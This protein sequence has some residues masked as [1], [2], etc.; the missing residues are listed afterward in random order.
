MAVAELIEQ[1]DPRLDVTWYARLQ[2]HSSRRTKALHWT[3]GCP[4][5]LWV[6][7]ARIQHLAGDLLVDQDAPLFEGSYAL[8]GLPEGHAAWP[9]ADCAIGLRPLP[10]DVWRTPL[11]EA[12]VLRVLALEGSDV[13]VDM[14]ARAGIRPGRRVRFTWQ[15]ME[16]TGFFEARTRANGRELACV[17]IDLVGRRVEIK[18]PL[19]GLELAS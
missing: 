3:R 10:V 19:S 9:C 18:V 15:G 12:E 5:H 11:S 8:H 2:I 4:C 1:R 17:L 7:T 14:A 6:P 13:S 16:C